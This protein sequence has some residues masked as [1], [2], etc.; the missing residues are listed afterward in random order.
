MKTLEQLLE[1]IAQN[2][3]NF[4]GYPVS[5]DFNI[6][7]LLP[8]F[9]YPL[10]NLGDPF[11]DTTYEVNTNELEREV[12]EYF[13]GLF[14]A[15]KDN[16]WGYV[17]NG[18]SEGNLYSLYLAREKY[19]KGIVYH[20]SS[21]H[22]S[23]RKNLHVLGME[24]ITIRSQQNGEMDYEDLHR[25]IAQ[26]RNSPVI[27]VANIGTTMTEAVDDIKRIQAVLHDLAIQHYY[28]H[29]DG[30]LGGIIRAFDDVSKLSFKLGVDSITLSGHK[31]IGS[32]IPCGVALVKK[33][34]RDRIALSISYTGSLD[35]TITGSRNGHTPL[36]LWDAIQ[37]LGVEGMKKRVQSCLEVA[38]YALS[39]F[40]KHRI[41]CW[42][43]TGAIT[44]VI[45]PQPKHIQAKWQLATEEKC[46][47]II[48]MPNVTKDQIDMVV[49]E[50]VQTGNAQFPVDELQFL[51]DSQ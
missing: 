40:Q 8:F 7:K 27:I 24:N 6:E 5:K 39:E 35:T 37:K 50:I 25:T 17:T 23:I 19:P 14:D 46:S 47:H 45:P 42:K 22:Y 31:F 38:D 18:G 3:E 9:N 44:V 29:C 32:P 26:H 30:A 36:I 11:V 1:K 48:C 33:T 41:A 20:S 51:V 12:V 4:L 49:S 2:T 34:N 10:N 21:T 13:A 16:W 15:P 28:I 43:N